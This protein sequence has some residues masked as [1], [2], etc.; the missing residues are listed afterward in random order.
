MHAHWEGNIVQLPR[1][2]YTGA[3]LSLTGLPQS[4][5]CMASAEPDHIITIIIEIVQKCHY[6]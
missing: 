3:H 5:W 1:Y 6:K 4:L 2:Y